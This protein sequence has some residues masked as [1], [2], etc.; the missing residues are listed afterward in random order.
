M[1]GAFMALFCSVGFVNAF[2]IFQEHYRSYQLSDYSDFDI[3]WIGSFATFALF[4]AAPLAGV[5]V[6]R[7]GPTVREH[8]TQIERR[9]PLTRC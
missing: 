9:E 3:S 2:G 7:I 4:A 1:L 6:D 8:N 5:L